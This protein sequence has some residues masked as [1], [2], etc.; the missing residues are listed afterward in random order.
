MELQLTVSDACFA[1]AAWATQAD[2]ELKKILFLERKGSVSGDRSLKIPVGK[3]LLIKAS[4]ALTE[5][6]CLL[7][8][9][10]VPGATG[11][12]G[13]AGQRKAFPRCCGL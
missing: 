3:E 11:K 7:E 4:D 10:E 2:L 12:G 1:P 9:S 6:E 5:Y 13:H 8:L